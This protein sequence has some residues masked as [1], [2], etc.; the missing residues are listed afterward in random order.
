[1]IRMKKEAPIGRRYI[2]SVLVSQKANVD[3]VLFEQLAGALRSI[4]A[5]DS[6]QHKK[7]GVFVTASADIDELLTL[8]R[9]DLGKPFVAMAG[10]PLTFGESIEGLRNLRLAF[11]SLDLKKF[12][13]TFNSH[14][15]FLVETELLAREGYRRQLQYS[16]NVKHDMDTWSNY[17]ASRYLKWDV[18]D[19]VKITDDELLSALHAAAATMGRGYEVN[20]QEVLCDSLATAARVLT[21]YAHGTP[22]ALLAQEYSKRSEWKGR[23][24]VS[25]YMQLTI[26]PELTHRAFLADTGSIVGPIRL[27][28]GYSVFKVLGKRRTTVKGFPDV[29]SVI[30]TIKDNLTTAKRRRAMNGYVAGLAKHYSVDINYEKLSAIKIEPANMFTRRNIGFGGVVTATPIL[31]PNWEWVKEYRDGGN[32]LP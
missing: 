10:K 26:H 18:D 21:E 32:T 5:R 16:D 1:M 11:T 13:G 6:T 31:Y 27:E 24:G 7:N 9:N 2:A 15:R 3:S 14:V 30:A 25:Q 29:D 22:L 23:G 8:F 12:K 20:I 4:I 28:G 17:W 19:T